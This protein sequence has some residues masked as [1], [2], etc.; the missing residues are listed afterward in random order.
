MLRLFKQYY[1]IRN[2][3][4]V[5]GEGIIIFL[6][7]IIACWIIIGE[8]SI[9]AGFGIS[10]KALLITCVCQLCLY[11]NDLYDLK[12]TDTFTELGIRLLQALGASAILLAVVY[13]VFP[14][15]IIS[16]GIFIVSIAIVIMFI[17]SWRIGYTHVLNHGLFNQRIII[18]GS[19][20][21]AKE[22]AKEIHA[23]KDCG[24]EI[25]AA[26]SKNLWS[27]LS[28]S[29]KFGLICQ[30]SYENICQI[31]TQMKVRKII[32]ALKEKRG[33]FPIKE[34]LECR[35]TGIDI[36]DGNSF[37]EMLT[38]KLIVEQIN[39]AWLIFSQGFQKSRSQRFL[40]RTID[41]ILSFTMLILLSPL[42]VTAAIIIKLDSKGPVIFSQERV[43]QKHKPYLVHKFRSMRTDAEKETGP[44]WAKDNDDRITRIGHFM[45][46][47][48]IDEIPQ[49]W[50]VLKGQ[51]SF[52]GPR[53]ERE[54]FVKQ[55]TEI[56]PYYGER[57][58]VKPGL[59]GWAQVSYGY[60]ASVRDAIEK[61]NYDL[62]YI[63][64]MAILMDIMIVARTVKTVLFGMGR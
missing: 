43:G 14:K 50:N 3:I 56:I 2:A 13:F 49:L 31:A 23:K 16:E 20:D 27:D 37:Y 59:T 21:T 12:I 17:V 7:V 22:I 18:L 58:S 47:W 54:H 8:K 45:R 26:V 53:P 15:V 52:V 5:L 32:V 63:K 57:F 35:V 39:P 36:I 46:K 48:R 40:K 10:M 64:N 1:P 28:C 44:V 61:L 11:Y 42:I 30:S 29:E 34:L 38:G 62:F 24:Y 60:G 9:Q 19:S 51:M 33:A 55:L 4:F 6:S 41:L 25:A